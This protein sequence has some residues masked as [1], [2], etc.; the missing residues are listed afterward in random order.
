MPSA[1]CAPRSRKR[2]RPAGPL[3]AEG[4]PPW[5][6]TGDARPILAE[7]API[8]A[9]LDGPTLVSLGRGLAAA[10]RLRAYGQRIRP[11]APGSRARGRV[12]R[13]PG[14][15]RLAPRRARSRWPLDRPRQSA[16]PRAPAANHDAPGR[17]PGASRAAPGS[18]HRP[19]RAPGA[20]RHRAE[21][22]LRDS[23]PG[24]GAP[25]RPGHHPRPVA[26]RRHGV[27]RARGDDPARTTSS[28][29]C[30]SRSG[31]RSSACSRS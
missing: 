23:R 6:G 13:I 8:G 26:E 2:P 27:R 28:R 24:R 1:L 18:P 7:A 5:D 17:A 10:A 15:R 30:A 19:A 9:V 16:T 21:R 4:P 12:A 20:L 31:T 3:T 14:L 25:R 29:V 22:P 11:V